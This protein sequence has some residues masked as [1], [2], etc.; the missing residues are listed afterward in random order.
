MAALLNPAAAAPHLS[1]AELLLAAGQPAQA[2]TRLEAATK[3]DPLSFDVALVLGRVLEAENR[4]ME[5]MA[6]YDRAIALNPAN[7]RARMLLVGAA[8]RAGRLDLAE[9]QLQQLLAMGYQPSRTHFALGRIAHLRGQLDVAERHYRE[10]L[11]LEPGLAM[12]EQ[13]LRQLR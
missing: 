3:I 9:Q 2:R 1:A 10:A 8:S 5:A 13:A 7:P 4:T 12:A 11:R 6:A